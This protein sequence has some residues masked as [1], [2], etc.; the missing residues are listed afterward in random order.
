MSEYVVY[1]DL[2]GNRKAVF[3][4]TWDTAK[5]HWHIIDNELIGVME[6]EDGKLNLLIDYNVSYTKEN[7]LESLRNKQAILVE[8]L[9]FDVDKF[10][11]L[12]TARMDKWDL[13]KEFYEKRYTGP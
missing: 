1:Q 13:V 10:I 9:G 5:D 6:R 7:I 12:D 11:K 4:N 2:K 3:Y 8:D